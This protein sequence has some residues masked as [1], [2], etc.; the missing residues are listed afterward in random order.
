VLSNST[1]RDMS[2]S[3]FFHVDIHDEI[4]PHLMQRDLFERVLDFT[5]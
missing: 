5:G 1:L 3:L 2:F 4:N